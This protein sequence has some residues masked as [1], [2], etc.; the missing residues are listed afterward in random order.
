MTWD[1]TVPMELQV[2]EEFVDAASGYES[3]RDFLRAMYQ[4]MLVERRRE[5]DRERKAEVRKALRTKETRAERRVCAN[6]KCPRGE[7]GNRA[8]FYVSLPS[9]GQPKRFCCKQCEDS[10]RKRRRRATRPG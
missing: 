10:T 4:D 2:A 3:Q 8:V 5:R 6:P 9:R 1:E 7:N